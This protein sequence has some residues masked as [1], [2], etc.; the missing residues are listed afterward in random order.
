MVGGV[1]VGQ[2]QIPNLTAQKQDGGQLFGTAELFL[3][4]TG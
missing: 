4:Q 1:A 3:R 2:G